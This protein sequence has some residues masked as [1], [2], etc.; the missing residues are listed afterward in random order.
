MPQ[1]LNQ[2]LAVEKS[3]KTRV[4]TE[5][6]AIYQAAQ[7]KELFQG[8]TRTY[9]PKN[10]DGD[11]LPDER[12]H[13]KARVEDQFAKVRLIL[14]ELFDTVATKDMSNTVARADV[15][16]D[17][18][19]L[20]KDVPAMHL[21]WLEKKLEN[22]AQFIRSLPMQDPAHSW[23]KDPANNLYR[24]EPVKSIKTA[25]VARV[26]TLAPATPQHPANVQLQHE[27]VVVGSWE[28]TYLTGALP[29]ARVEELEQ[30]VQ[31]LQHAVKSG[32]EQANVVEAVPLKSSVLLDYIFAPAG[33]Q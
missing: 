20:L 14:G 23:A 8:L 19:V 12:Q 31:K 33:K 30:R 1:K 24:T 25:K 28:T 4:E 18:K 9:T 32:R 26:I 11:K 29:M 3:L 5:F 10:D 16:V 7:K 22:V 2:V 21:L 17:G 15:I 27:D 6:T 13:V